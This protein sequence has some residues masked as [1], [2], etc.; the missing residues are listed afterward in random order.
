MRSVPAEKSNSSCHI[1]V[2]VKHHVNTFTSIERAWPVM[3][4]CFI[5]LLLCGVGTIFYLSAKRAVMKKELG[6]IGRQIT[7]SA[8]EIKSWKLLTNHGVVLLFKTY[9]TLTILS[10]VF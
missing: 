1:N 10:F 4:M 7:G 3:R 6:S 2:K 9:W 5:L 8:K